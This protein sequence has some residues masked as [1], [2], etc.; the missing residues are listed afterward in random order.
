M[1]YV[2]TMRGTPQLYYGTELLFT[3]AKR[4][5]HGEIR[6]D[7]PGGW[8]G[9]A[10]NAFTGKGLSADQ[11]EARDFIRTINQWRKNAPV[12]HEGTVK[13]FAP[14]DNIYVF[15]RY[16]DDGMVMTVINRN[17]QDR[18]IDISRLSEVLGNRTRGKDI[19][20]GT[21]VTLNGTLSVKAGEPMIIELD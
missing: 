11:L 1:A 4:G 19:L 6:K 12:I 18:E 15:F 14:F 2:L 8:D 10:V 13:H 20:T 21:A 16:N 9:D 17:S 3:N 5:D 7:Y